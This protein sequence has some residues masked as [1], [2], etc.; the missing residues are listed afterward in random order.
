[1]T[2]MAFAYFIHNPRPLSGQGL[3]IFDAVAGAEME[4][5][6]TT[7]VAKAF[8]ASLAAFGNSFALTPPCLCREAAID[9]IMARHI[10]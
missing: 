3:I 10:H 2:E 1:M 7:T 8:S 6:T 4:R 9:G 5:R